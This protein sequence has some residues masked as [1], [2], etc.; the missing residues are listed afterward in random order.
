LA[1]GAKDIASADTNERKTVD[2]VDAGGPPAS[3]VAASSGSNLPKKVSKLP[4]LIQAGRLYLRAGKLAACRY[5][6][7]G[8]DR[9]VTFRSP[10]QAT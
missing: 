10:L 8:R 5:G 9:L 3:L 2:R 7:L 6:G 1:T 4:R